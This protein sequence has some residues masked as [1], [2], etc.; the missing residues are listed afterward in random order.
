M[1]CTT[2]AAKSLRAW[3][4]VTT[5]GEALRV[6]EL[7]RRQWVNTPLEQV[8]GFCERA[9]NLSHITPASL[10]FR[11]LTPSP[12]RMSE[13]RLID[14]RLRLAGFPL[15]W[16]SEIAVYRPPHCFVDRQCRGPYALWH[17]T[18][19]FESQNNRSCIVDRVRYVLPR[20]LPSPLEALVH[21]LWIAPYLE[22]IFDYRAQQF[23]ARF[24]VDQGGASSACSISITAR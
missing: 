15:A 2:T 7:A 16:R 6:H 18:H 8:F 20:W 4:L 23:A 14:Y 3:L 11:V 19:R 12:I 13:G 1:V 17:H 24:G 22:R 5:G 21:R 9:E 10:G